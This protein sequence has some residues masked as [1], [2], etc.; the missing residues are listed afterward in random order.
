MA[1]I[2]DPLTQLPDMHSL[3]DVTESI[4]MESFEK[5]EDRESFMDKLYM[6][7]LSDPNAP[8]PPG[9]GED[10]DDGFDS[11]LGAFT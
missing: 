8:L 4:V 2:S 7:D 11:F 6:P 3:L 5:K 10:D 1:G 9:F